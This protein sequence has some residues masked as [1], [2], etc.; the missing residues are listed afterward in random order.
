MWVISVPAWGERHVR[1][2]CSHMIPAIL[3]SLDKAQIPHE[4]CAFV[5]HTD[6]PEQFDSKLHS[7]NFDIADVPPGGNKY[8]QFVA[9]HRDVLG[10]AKIGDAVIFINADMVCSI[11]FFAA[12]RAR[13]EQGKRAV[14]TLGSRT[15][16][17]GSPPVGVS[18]REL[19]AWGWANRHHWIE[20]SVWGR[21]RTVMPSELY[22]EQPGQVV[23]H[24]FFHAPVAF[25][26]QPGMRIETTIDDDFASQFARQDLHVVSDA[27]EL[28]FVELS[29]PGRLFASG[30]ALSVDGVVH[31]A[32]R[33]MRNRAGLRTTPLHR[34]LF[35]HRRVIMGD[36]RMGDVEREVCGEIS[37]RLA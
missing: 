26:K 30:D 20:D 8:V 35:S 11:E 17:D 6:R 33:Q 16:A 28:S 15:S 1:C 27:D 12:V 3:M 21:G 5:V 10:R 7:E 14:M 24:A 19:L 29:P 31:W 34:W 37:A 4:D 18:S 36:G 9:A 2:A 23:L 25:L 22:F 32:N 13:F